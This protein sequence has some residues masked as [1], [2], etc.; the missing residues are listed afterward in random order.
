VGSSL[1]PPEIRKNIL[2]RKKR[3]WFGAAAACLA[4]AAASV[5]LNNSMAMGRLNDGLGSLTNA[6]PIVSP[7]VED[8][9]RTIE[10]PPNILAPVEY[11]AKLGGAVQKLKTEF[12]SLQDPTQS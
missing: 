10:S 5:W 12:T 11:A 8:A 3:P 9:Q 7:T 4:G 2:W 6:Q 1:L